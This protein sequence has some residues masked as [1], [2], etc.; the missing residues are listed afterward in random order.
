MTGR[1]TLCS[2]F[3]GFFLVSLGCAAFILGLTLGT[4][5]AKRFTSPTLCFFGNTSYSVYLTHVAIL[6]LMHGLLL[7]SQP[8]IASWRQIAVTIAALPVAALVGWIFTKIVE[9]PITQLRAQFPLEPRDAARFD[10]FPLEAAILLKSTSAIAA[11]WRE[12]L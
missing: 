5:E 2:K 1:R 8:D 4:P 11:F 6:G 10:A 7:G 3:F 12:R 9:E